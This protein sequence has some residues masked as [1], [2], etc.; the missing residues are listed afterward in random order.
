MDQVTN[1]HIL[2]AI[3]LA[4]LRMKVACFNSDLGRLEEE[5]LKKNVISQEAAFPHLSL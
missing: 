5:L 4:T 1:R 2:N 3:E